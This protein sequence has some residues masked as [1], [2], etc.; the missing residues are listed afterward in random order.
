LDGVKEIDGVGRGGHAVFRNGNW[1][2][3]PH[4]VLVVA[5]EG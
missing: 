2:E 4:A 5:A 3:R 1:V